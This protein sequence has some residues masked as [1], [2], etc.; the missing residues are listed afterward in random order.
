[1]KLCINNAGAAVDLRVGHYTD[2]VVYSGLYVP[3][4]RVSGSLRFSAK[5]L[6][7]RTSEV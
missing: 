1:M 6:R 3:V 7:I 4:H 5:S 2:L